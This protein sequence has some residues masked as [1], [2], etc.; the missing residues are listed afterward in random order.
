MNLSEK[1]VTQPS[2]L[3]QELRDSFDK[4]VIFSSAGSGE[5]HPKG[6]IKELPEATSSL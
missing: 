6:D 2:A 4:T 5:F 3:K 1:G